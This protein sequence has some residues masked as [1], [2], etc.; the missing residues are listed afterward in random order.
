M[1]SF[2]GQDWAR[3]IRRF[4]ALVILGDPGVVSRAG[5]GPAERIFKWG[6]GGANEKI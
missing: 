1:Q 3:K 5:T 4:S 6:G 2:L